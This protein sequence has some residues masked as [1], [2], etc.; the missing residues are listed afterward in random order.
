MADLNNLFENLIKECVQPPVTHSSEIPEID[1]Y[2]D[3]VTTFI[4]DKLKEY[5]RWENDKL[6]TKTMINNYT[7]NDLL[8]RPCKKKYGKNHI[9]SLFFIFYLKQ[10]LSI[11]DIKQLFSLYKSTELFETKE[12]LEILYNTYIEIMNSFSP[13]I[14][15]LL[16]KQ[17]QSIKNLLKE[18]ELDTDMNLTFLFIM[19][20]ITQG[21]TNKLLAQKII[22]EFTNSDVKEISDQP[23]KK[24]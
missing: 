19:S 3:Q 1:L 17:Y 5:R 11:Q 2:M 22:D 7:K 14:Q 16:E 18:K 24:S 23:K 21:D 12:D 6:L 13:M 15:E 9:M 10:I 20:I 8:P 4:E